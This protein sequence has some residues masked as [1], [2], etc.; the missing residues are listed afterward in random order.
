M[1]GFGF[2]EP[3][4]SSRPSTSSE[5]SSSSQCS[6]PRGAG[7]SGQPQGT[8]GSASILGAVATAVPLSDPLAVAQLS[9]LLP[10][11]GF[12]EQQRW[13]ARWARLRARQPSHLD[14]WQWVWAERALHALRPSVTTAALVAF[15]AT[16]A[17]AWHRIAF[18]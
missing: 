5:S 17:A 13:Q 18:P 1:W 6:Q 4:C 9:A 2:R 7:T 14:D 12:A 16:M 15:L 3:S 11:R 10:L 8:G